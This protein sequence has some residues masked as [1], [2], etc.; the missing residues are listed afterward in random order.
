MRIVA[1]FVNFCLCLRLCSGA[2]EIAS[3]MTMDGAVTKT[4]LKMVTTLHSSTAV[5]GR[6]S[7]QEGEVLE[8]TFSMPK[9]KMELLDVQ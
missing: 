8:A 6:V 7:L 5:Q 3:L 9:E 2:V 1:I 4:G